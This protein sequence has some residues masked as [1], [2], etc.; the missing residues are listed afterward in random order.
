V[1]PAAAEPKPDAEGVVRTRTGWRKLL[2]DILG[3]R[4]KDEA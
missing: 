4:G 3:G 1:A 2:P